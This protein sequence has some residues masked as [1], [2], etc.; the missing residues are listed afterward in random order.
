MECG[1]WDIVS[2]QSS[3]SLTHDQPLTVS[4]SLRCGE[5]AEGGR[6]QGI[7]I[8]LGGTIWR[9]M[10]GHFGVRDVGVFELERERTFSMSFFFLE[11]S[12]FWKSPWVSFECREIRLQQFEGRICLNFLCLCSSGAQFF[13]YEAFI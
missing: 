11:P 4:H 1:S 2:A 5:R 3:L 10:C 13:N 7:C 8:Y 6:K 9:R 12:L